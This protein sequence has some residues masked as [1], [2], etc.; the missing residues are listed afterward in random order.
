M[1][2]LILLLE[3]ERKRINAW[4]SIYA[5]NQEKK[6][7][8]CSESSFMILV[9]TLAITVLEVEAAKKYLMVAYVI[10][11][12]SNNMLAMNTVSRKIM[13]SI[14]LE[15][16]LSHMAIMPNGTQACVLHRGDKASMM[17]MISYRTI[18]PPLS[19]SHSSTVAISPKGDRVYIMNVTTSEVFIV[20]PANNRVIGT[21]FVE[22]GMTRHDGIAVTPGGTCIC[23]TNCNRG[24][25]SFINA[26]TR[27]VFPI[28]VGKQPIRV[29]VAPNGKQAYVVNCGDSTVS[30]IDTTTYKVLL[31]SVLDAVLVALP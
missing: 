30:V 13:F 19:I 16:E 14:K 10:V 23:V 28:S 11:Y 5:N 25:V 27:E 1:C 6:S 12:G 24:T 4:Y 21:I 9:R 20:D 26:I 18:S 29:A 8:I 7:S 2:R 31:L 17:D 22:N 3:R 15:N